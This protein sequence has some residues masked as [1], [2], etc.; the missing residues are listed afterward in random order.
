MAKPTP[1][2]LTALALREALPGKSDHDLIELKLSS[3]R[4]MLENMAA[5]SMAIGR[6]E[7]Y[8]AAVRLGEDAKPAIY[9]VSSAL[10]GLA[11]CVSVLIETVPNADEAIAEM[12][13]CV[14]AR[15]DAAGDYVDRKV[16]ALQE[17]MNPAAEG[18][19]GGDE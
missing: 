19:S 3:I 12:V 4:V 9:G 15:V 17:K 18:E 13:R 8:T 1:K 6:N 10:D 14:R 7:G 11:D 16:M 5:M 2:N